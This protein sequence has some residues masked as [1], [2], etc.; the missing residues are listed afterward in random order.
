MR[1]SLSR[2]SPILLCLKST[3]LPLNTHSRVTASKPSSTAAPSCVFSPSPINYPARVLHKEGE[4]PTVVSLLRRAEDIPIL[5]QKVGLR[6]C[7]GYEF[8][9]DG[10]D[11]NIG[12]PHLAVLIR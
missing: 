10:F 1:R 3:V 9:I 4:R 8:I 12:L 11:I 2:I 6:S 5:G 7:P